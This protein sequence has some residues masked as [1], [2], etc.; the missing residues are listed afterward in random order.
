MRL[1]LVELKLEHITTKEAV[2]ELIHQIHSDATQVIEA[3]IAKG[4][5]KAYL[6][7]EAEK[8]DFVE[9]ALYQH[10]LQ[11]EL[12]KEVRL[13]GK[14]RAEVTSTSD[15]VNYLVEWDLPEHLTMDQYLERKK[16]NSVHYQE[17]PEVTFSRTY[18]CEDM[19]KCLC[20]YNAPNEDAVKKARAAV[21][22]PITSLTKLE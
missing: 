8:Q 6:I 4:F 12:I 19:T 18:V 2:Q 7:L 15:S 5:R 20:F 3:Q 9:E 14:D 21:K 13:I 16:K 22:A 1:F 11:I 10:N 17:V